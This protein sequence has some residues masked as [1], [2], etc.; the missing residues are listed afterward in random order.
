MP[1]KKKALEIPA[2]KLTA[3]AYLYLFWYVILPFLGGLAL[4]DGLLYLFFK[5]A[6]N[7]CYGILCF[8]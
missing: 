1:A 6:L 8:L 4:L 5:Y 7:S 3:W 2:P